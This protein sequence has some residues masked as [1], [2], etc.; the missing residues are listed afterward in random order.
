MSFLKHIYIIKEIQYTPYYLEVFVLLWIK[1]T[2]PKRTL[3]QKT[4]QRQTSKN[5]SIKAKL[6]EESEGN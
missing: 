1:H 4:K 2:P 6:E 3:S 5:V